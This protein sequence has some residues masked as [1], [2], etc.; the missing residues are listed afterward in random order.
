MIFVPSI[1]SD[2]ERYFL[3][4]WV[5]FKEMGETLFFI[6]RVRP[7][8]IEGIYNNGEAFQLKMDEEAPYEMVYNLPTRGIFPYKNAVYHL[9]RIPAKQYRRGI[10]S[11][12]TQ[13]TNVFTGS[14]ISITEAVL[15]AFT[16][17]PTH[18]PLEEALYGKTPAKVVGFVVGHR[19]SFFRGD[20]SLWVDSTKVAI[21]NR[22]AKTIT[23]L[24]KM[25][26]FKDEIKALGN[27]E[28]KDSE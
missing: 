28:V 5:K 13:I 2:I 6:N 12:N 24:P 10:C 25:G 26:I 1:S 14:V 22:E 11:D 17:K 16:N 18:T 7:D 15:T 19:V 8:G 27:I 21:F 9:C 20:Q 23:M 3:N 4:T